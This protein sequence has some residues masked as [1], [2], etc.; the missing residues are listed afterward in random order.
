M[1]LPIDVKEV[2]IA[3]M[4]AMFPSTTCLPIFPGRCRRRFFREILR[5]ETFRIERIVSRGQASPPGFWYDQ[6]TDE[7]VLLVSGARRF[8]STTAGRSI[9]NPAITSSSPG[10]SGTVWS[11]R[12]RN[13]RQSGSPVHFGGHYT[14]RQDGSSGCIGNFGKG[15]SH[16]LLT[17]WLYNCSVVVV[18]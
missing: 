4:I 1:S 5:T 9:S 13:R 11:G 15:K 17:A 12:S 2:G 18:H 6:E 8:A 7:W 14:G 16:E 10:M 3:G